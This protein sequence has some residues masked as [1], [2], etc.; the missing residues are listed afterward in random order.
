VGSQSV[1]KGVRQKTYSRNQKGGSTKRHWENVIFERSH[2]DLSAANPPIVTN[3]K[4]IELKMS[5]NQKLRSLKN[6]VAYQKHK[7]ANDREAVASLKEEV[8]VLGHDKF[9]FGCINEKSAKRYAKV[10]LDADKTLERLN[11][12]TA[13]FSSSLH[14]KAAEVTITKSGAK[15]A[16][17]A[18]K[19][20]HEKELSREDSVRFKEVCL[21]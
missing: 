4:N 3:S 12:R 5:K 17:S 2:G 20:V 19:K 6:Q 9:G 14:K 7:G 8:K 15:K 13:Q 1:G 11:A 21:Q 18:I 10:Q 16:L